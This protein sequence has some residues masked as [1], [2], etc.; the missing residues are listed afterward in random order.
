[1]RKAG[2]GRLAYGSLCNLCGFIPGVGLCWDSNVGGGGGTRAKPLASDVLALERT[3][4][5]EGCARIAPEE[6]EGA[7][8]TSLRPLPDLGELCGAGTSEGECSGLLKYTTRV[9]PG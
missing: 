7:F 1:M 4:T 6:P 2:R 9:R 8:S 3:E 5:R